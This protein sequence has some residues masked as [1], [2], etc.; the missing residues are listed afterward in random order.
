MQSAT[1]R[2]G[3]NI[4]FIK[5]WGVADPTLNLPLNNSI[6]MTL[7]NVLTTTTVAWDTAG[8]LPTDEI[9]LDGT[10]VA[11]ASRRAP[12]APPG[13]SA[14]A[15]RRGVA[16]HSAQRQQLSHGRGHRQ[17]SQWL[18]RAHR[19]RLRSPGT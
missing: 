8:T 16:C 19:G 4:A 7:A 5:Y 15:G 3:S 17:F 1:A 12:G 11:G 9:D 2:A 14:H 6:S 13:P 18:R 10:R